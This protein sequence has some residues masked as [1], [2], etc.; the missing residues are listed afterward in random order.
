MVLTTVS[1]GFFAYRHT[2]TLPFVN[3]DSFTLI[4]AGR[5]QLFKDVT[6]VFRE[7]I[8]SNMMISSR[9]QFFR[10]VSIL[11][12]SFMYSVF[13]LDAFSYH[14]VNLVLHLGVSVLVFFFVRF[15]LNG[16]QVTAWIS[17]LIFSSHHMV[18]E[19]LP[20][21][22][23]RPDI[24][25]TLFLLLSLL[26]FVKHSTSALKRKSFLI[27]SLIFYS[28]ALSTKEIPII[29][30]VLVF[31]YLMFFSFPEVKALKSKIVKSV[32]GTM[33]YLIITFIFFAWRTYVLGGL[34]GYL[35]R[36]SRLFEYI[37]LVVEYTSEYIAD[38]LYPLNFL[39]FIFRPVPSIVEKIGFLL[40]LIALPIFL[41]LSRRTIFR[42]VEQKAQKGKRFLETILASLALLSLV[43][44]L[45]YPF[46]AP[47]L[48]HLTEQAYLGQGPKFLSSLMV[49]KSSTPLETYFSRVRDLLVTPLI[50]L[51]LFSAGT[52]FLI[53]N[54][55]KSRKFFSTVKGKSV[56]FFLIWTI[57]PLG[58]FLVTL[59]FFH[60]YTYSALVPMS[61]LLAILLVASFKGSFFSR[62]LLVRAN[63]TAFILLTGLLVALLALSPLFR[64]YG[65]WEDGGKISSLFLDKLARI[66]PS[67]PDNAF[68]EIYNMPVTIASYEAKNVHVREVRYM[69]DTGIKSWLNLHYPENRMEVAIRSIS[70]PHT[71]PADL[72]L[73]VVK[74]DGRN[75]ALA[76]TFTF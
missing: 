17:A 27:F 14:F 40:V 38:L 22:S 65:E 19:T 44:L 15:M 34:G 33:P 49:W 28:L 50:F 30:P 1:I 47:S 18:I 66:I 6:T 43:L 55:E 76:V 8:M 31:S 42:V 7:P 73:E 21:A 32:M 25:S 37:K 2:L 23:R 12:S 69:F 13:G 53:H 20:D 75:F 24:L 67:L 60:W 10:P 9:I 74:M 61:S 57:L 26:F 56:A 4:Q 54:W 58:I 72:G 68:L 41:F 36:S 48:N 5:D 51:F 59:T 45:S 52:F 70:R 46:L 16:S 62:S 64:K 11:F 29:L 35:N 39:S 63:R 71:C 3:G